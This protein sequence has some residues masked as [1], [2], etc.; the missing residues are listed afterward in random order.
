MFNDDNSVYLPA[1]SPVI[2]CRLSN[3]SMCHIYRQITTE[4]NFPNRILKTKHTFFCQFRHSIQQCQKNV[5]ILR[6]DEW[7]IINLAQILM[8][9]IS[10]KKCIINRTNYSINFTDQLVKHV[11]GF[12]S[13]CFLAIL[14]RSCSLKC[15]ICNRWHDS[16]LRIYKWFHLSIIGKLYNVNLDT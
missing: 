15:T 10:K 6:N 9:G 14:H 3:T 8:R 5:W 7:Y 12:L 2:T 13:K 11:K 4:Y 16:R 1:P